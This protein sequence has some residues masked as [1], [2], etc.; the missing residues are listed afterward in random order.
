MPWLAEFEPLIPADRAALVGAFPDGVSVDDPMV[1]RIGGIGAVL[2]FI[3]TSEAWLA[4]R[5]AATR[6]IAIT[7]G[8][9]R[10]VGEYEVDL[11][12]RGE[13]FA[14]PVAVMIEPKQEGRRLDVRVYYS[15][16]PLTGAHQL[17]HPLL[18]EDAA[19]HPSD[20][21][22]EYQAAL[23][24][25]DLERIV[26]TFEPEGCFREPSGPQYRRCGTDALTE[27]FG[28][29]FGAGG[30]IGLEHCTVTEDGVRSAL[31]YNAVRWGSTELPR[32]AGIAVYERGASGRIADAR[33]YD[34]VAGPVE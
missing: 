15:Q 9:S 21:V 3:A 5:N 27:L 14:L 24:A 19:Q 26:A 28:R 7:N 4:E 29:F 12:V 2:D 30:G 20:I 11:T 33:V 22:G 8:P 1:G 10:R 32:S 31:E 16:W 25:G 23:A 13:T 34:D 18:A 17:R 6:L